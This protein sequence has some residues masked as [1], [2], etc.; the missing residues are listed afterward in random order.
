MNYYE[1]LG[2]DKSATSDE[3][4]KAFRKKAIETHPDKGGSDE[5]FQK[6]S[7]AYEIL[8]DNEKK[9][10]YDR[11]GSVDNNR[12]QS[13]GFSMDDIFSQFGDIF[14]NGGQY[15]Q[16]QKRGS[17][18]RVQ[19]TV[20]LE[21][22]INGSTKKIKYKRQVPCN[23][24]N[25]KGGTDIK[26]CLACSGTGSRSMV[27]NTPFG[28]IRQNIS[29]NNCNGT[30][31]KISNPCQSCSGSGSM[32]IEETIDINIPKGVSGGMNL[33]MSGYGNSIQDGITGDL[34]ILIQEIQHNKFT[35]DG[36]DLYC[37][38]WIEIP[39]AVLGTKINIETLKGN[40]SLN[41]EPG[42]ESGKVFTSK[43]KGVPI[44]SSNGQI[45]GNGNLHVRVNVR[46]PKKISKQE[47][48]LYTKISNL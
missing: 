30:G 35:R 34:H 25:G 4:K 3:I 21:D 33:S 32:S 2:V 47:K 26:E 29:C 6:V 45:Y 1:V 9:E 40:V 48:E 39:E 7:E 46:I 8:S 14:G 18:L 36:S 12:F 41:I 16:R 44:L 38:E 20:S 43:G 13:H 42:C 23:P 19:I 10:Q 28:Q 22:V 5:Q 15:R 11:Y 31:K 17:D 24:C 37:D 27:Q